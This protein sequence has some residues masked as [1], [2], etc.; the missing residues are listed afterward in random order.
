[1]E[2]LFIT[3]SKFSVSRLTDNKV[4]LLKVMEQIKEA[5]A[6]NYYKEIIKQDGYKVEFS[7]SKFGTNWST[8]EI[9]Y[10]GRISF[11][12]KMTNV[13][14]KQGERLKKRY[15]NSLIQKSVTEGVYYYILLV[16]DNITESN[17][18]KCLM[19]IIIVLEADGYILK[20]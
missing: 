13:G 7:M 18:T 4:M 6:L 15:P 1:M 19:D 9:D 8:F 11:R 17:L 12:G 2:N 5:Y 3:N 20:R 14:V 10:K 16:I